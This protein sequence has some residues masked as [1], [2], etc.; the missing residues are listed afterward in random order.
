MLNNMLLVQQ[1][2]QRTTDDHT[3]SPKPTA[4][5]QFFG[6]NFLSCPHLLNLR[7]LGPILGRASGPPV[8]RPGCT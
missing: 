7:E 4:D 2:S 1:V 5:A 8:L 6:A 3:L